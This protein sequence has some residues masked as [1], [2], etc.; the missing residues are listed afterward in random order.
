MCHLC[1]YTTSLIRLMR[2]RNVLVLRTGR[3][4]EG[5]VKTTG[6]IKIWG[7]EGLYGYTMKINKVERVCTDIK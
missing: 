2:H 4:Y 3:N 5:E 1:M 6:E 7:G